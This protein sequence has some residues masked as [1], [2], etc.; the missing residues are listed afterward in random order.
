MKE[1]AEPPPEPARAAVVGAF[2]AVYLI[3][4]STYLAI[5]F[6]IESIPPLLMAGVRFSVAGLLLYAWLRWRGAARPAGGEWRH[7][8]VVGAC[9]LL[10]GNGGVTLAELYIPSSL[11]ALLV[12]TVPMFMALLGWLA[13]QASRPTW[14]VWLG[15]IVGFA[16]VGLLVQPSAASP[17]AAPGFRLGVAL[18][19]GA[20]LIWSCGSLYARNAGAGG[21]P[22]VGAALQMITGGAMLV[23]AG[24]ALGEGARLDFTAI[25]ARSAAAF[26]YLLLIGSII[27]F[28][29]YI[30]LLRHRP[31]AQVAT[32]AYVNPMVAVLLGATLGGEMLTRSMLAGAVLI[33]AAVAV[34]ITVQSRPASK[35]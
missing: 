7:A 4:G 10:G 3:W 33:V 17:L 16:G 34:V 29:A 8:A 27:G 19:L 30:W 35:E 23:V 24:L 22:M 26:L 11:A 6:A 31:P 15:L 32:Y 2:A 14:L 18:V 28:T 9:L 12:A 21:A 25:S 13:G 1:A 20:A 5:R